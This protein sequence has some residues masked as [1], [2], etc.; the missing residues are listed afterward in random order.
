MFLRSFDLI[1]NFDF[2]NFHLPIY[3][4]N[5]TLFITYEIVMITVNNIL[6]PK[7]KMGVNKCLLMAYQF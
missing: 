5:F 2:G 7:I 6:L 4:V 1:N 3:K